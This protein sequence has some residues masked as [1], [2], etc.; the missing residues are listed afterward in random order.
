MYLRHGT[1]MFDGSLAALSTEDP[2]RDGSLRKFFLT[3]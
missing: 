3:A 1:I 2:G